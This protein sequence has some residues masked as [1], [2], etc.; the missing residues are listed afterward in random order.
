M[1][2]TLIFQVKKNSSAMV[3]SRQDYFIISVMLSKLLSL[4]LSQC[5]HQGQEYNLSTF[6]FLFNYDYI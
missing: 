6:G 5:L 3:K 4:S 2:T 1:L